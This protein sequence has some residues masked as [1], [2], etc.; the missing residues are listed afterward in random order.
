MSSRKQ[1]ANSG[2]RYTRIVIARRFWAYQEGL[3][4]ARNRRSLLLLRTS[5]NRRRAGDLTAAVG[6]DFLPAIRWLKER[7]GF[8][9]FALHIISSL[10]PR[11]L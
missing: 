11:D 2:R 1:L 3:L 4:R 7:L 9:A 8:K 5:A 6:T 10:P